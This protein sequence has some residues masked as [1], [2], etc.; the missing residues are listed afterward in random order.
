MISIA[1][2]NHHCPENRSLTH[3]A[4]CFYLPVALVTTI[5]LRPHFVISQEDWS[6]GQPGSG[7][8]RR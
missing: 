7:C 4:L 5:L 8:P 2:S 1:A 6:K 3:W